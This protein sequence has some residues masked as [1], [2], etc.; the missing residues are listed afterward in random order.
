MIFPRPAIRIVALRIG[1]HRRILWRR[2]LGRF[3]RRWW[4]IGLGLPGLPVGAVARG[5]RLIRLNRR[6]GL[7]IIVAAIIPVLAWIL[8]SIVPVIVRCIRYAVMISVVM[9][10]MISGSIIITAWIIGGLDG[11]IPRIIPIAEVTVIA[12]KIGIDGITDGIKGHFAMGEALG[13]INREFE[14]AIE[15]QLRADDLL[16]RRN[17]LHQIF[18]A[19]DIAFGDQVTDNVLATFAELFRG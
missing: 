2:L 19:E 9:L 17:T 6:R 5:L 3:Y 18:S 4:W 10:A 16:G 7:M 14:T 12:G 11:T 1:P 8:I 15:F 13:F